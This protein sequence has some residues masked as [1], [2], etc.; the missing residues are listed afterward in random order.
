MFPPFCRYTLYISRANS[1][2]RLLNFAWLSC[3]LIMLFC[4]K[5]VTHNDN[6]LNFIFSVTFRYFLFKDLITS[7]YFQR[8]AEK[9]GR[10][11]KTGTYFQESFLCRYIR[12][13][14]D[15]QKY[16]NIYNYLRR[17]SIGF[18]IFKVLV[19]QL[20]WF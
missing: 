6:Y 9:N 8:M 2:L 7:L 12:K 3:Y 19:Y 15:T 1:V 13:S 5:E 14:S 4:R 17:I 11:Q 10:Q 18:F 20:G 16:Y